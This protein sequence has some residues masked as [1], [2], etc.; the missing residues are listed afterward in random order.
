MMP[1][2][3]LDGLFLTL[4]AAYLGIGGILAAVGFGYAPLAVAA[5]VVY[6]M[7]RLFKS[8]TRARA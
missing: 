4:S 8:M 5:G 6:L 1:T 2:D 3:E 7:R